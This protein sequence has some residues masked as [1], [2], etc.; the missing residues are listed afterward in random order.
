LRL[1]LA[2]TPRYTSHVSVAE[3][4]R[5]YFEDGLSA[6]E[7]ARF[8]AALES[9]RTGCASLSVVRALLSSWVARFEVDAL[10]QQTWFAPFPQELVDAADSGEGRAR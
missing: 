2:K 6:R 10:A 1:L 5:G 4:A 8:R 3:R 7:K 9:Y